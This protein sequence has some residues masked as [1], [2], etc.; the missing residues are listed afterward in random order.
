M[1]RK[2]F[3]IILRIYFLVKW[4]QELH[5][6][7]Q[8]GP[9]AHDDANKM[10]ATGKAATL[11]H[12]KSFIESAVPPIRLLL[13]IIMKP[14]KRCVAKKNY[15]IP[16]LRNEARNN[17]LM[18]GPWLSIAKLWQLLFSAPRWRCC[19]LIFLSCNVKFPRS[20]WKWYISL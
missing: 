10:G 14:L 2:K 19:Y 6:H 20:R 16:L 4:P 8:W 9:G 17:F 18:S 11:S 12:I 15:L 3:Q 13:M 7:S 5:L 1:R